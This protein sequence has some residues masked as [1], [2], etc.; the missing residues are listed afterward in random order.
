MTI[1]QEEL[2]RRL[3]V[4]R[5]ACGMT[6]EKVAAHLGVSRPTVAQMELGNRAVTSLELDTL[7]HLYGRDL[8]EFFALDFRPEDALVA[9]FRSHPDVA[10]EVDSLEPLRKCLDLGRE[11]TN[12]ERLIG[13]DREGAVLPDYNM[14]VPR[15]RWDAIQHGERAAVAERRRLGLGT[16]PLPNVAELLE[17]QGVRT[18]QVTL[19][20]DVSGLTVV[21]QDVGALVVANL[22]HAFPRRRF[23]YAHEYCHVLLDRARKAAISRTEERDNVIEVRANAFAAAF[24]MPAEGVHEFVEAFAKGRPSRLRAEIFDEDQP[25]RAESRPEPGSQS[26]QIY[27][28]V[29]LAHHFK[30]SRV[31]A[32]YRL[33]NLKLVNQPEFDVLLEQEES[34]A[35]R[36]VADFLELKGP[37]PEESRHEFLRRF[38]A[39]GF[40]AFRRGEISRGKLVELARLVQVPDDE[41]DRILDEAGLSGVDDGID[42]LI[43]ED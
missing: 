40:E 23:S 9:L 3:R 18:A 27:D 1:T 19:P 30:V 17:N 14:P 32:L 7:A 34:G 13:I 6:Q 2:A 16:A 43:P 5:E 31:S 20:E 35:G 10:D 38:L 24:L 25:L 33:K 36:A 39:L 28:V 22:E 8:R 42:A 29:L 11:I 37:D 4:G 41:V 12:L 26:I 21:A 15:T